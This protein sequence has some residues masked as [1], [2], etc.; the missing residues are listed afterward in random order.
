MNHLLT[1][2]AFSV[3]D[4]IQRK[5]VFQVPFPCMHGNWQFVFLRYSYNCPLL[6]YFSSILFDY[7][8]SIVACYAFYSKSENK[9]HL[10]VF[11]LRAHLTEMDK[12]FYCLFNN[13]YVNTKYRKTKY[14]Y[15]LISW[16]KISNNIDYGDKKLSNKFLIDVI[17]PKYCIF[18]WFILFLWHNRHHNLSYEIILPWFTVELDIPC[19]FMVRSQIKVS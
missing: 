11:Y 7:F 12:H 16:T 3:Y 5:T 18:L 4:K 19:L 10:L 15:I 8:C 9:L 13:K 14:L 17:Y 6:F 1:T 2:V